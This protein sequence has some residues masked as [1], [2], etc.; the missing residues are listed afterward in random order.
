MKERKKAG[1][2]KKGKRRLK[3]DI[4]L[5]II[6]IQALFDAMGKNKIT[7]REYLK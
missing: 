5:G 7:Q 6:K 1:K 3:K 2:R 4:D